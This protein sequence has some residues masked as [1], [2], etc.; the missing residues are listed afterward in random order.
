MTV[1]ETVQGSATGDDLLAVLQIL[2]ALWEVFVGCR[3]HGLSRRQDAI[4]NKD[5]EWLIDHTYRYLEPHDAFTLHYTLGM[6]DLGDYPEVLSRE[7]SKDAAFKAIRMFVLT[8][9]TLAKL[10]E[11]GFERGITLKLDDFVSCLY[12]KELYLQANTE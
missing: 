11:A 10:E 12:G 5:I 9:K 8:E 1:K 3:V 2:S 6:I 4:S 7:C